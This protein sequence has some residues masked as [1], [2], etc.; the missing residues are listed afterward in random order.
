MYVYENQGSAFYGA[1]LSPPWLPPASGPLFPA[2]GVP[3]G[4]LH[5]AIEFWNFKVGK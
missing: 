5:V 2:C 4:K 1:Y 3:Y